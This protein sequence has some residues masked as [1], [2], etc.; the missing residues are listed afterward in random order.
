MPHYIKMNNSRLHSYS[1]WE[2]NMERKYNTK[3]LSGKFGGLI[4]EENFGDKNGG[5]ELS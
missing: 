1:F 4:L 3:I 5:I 2:H